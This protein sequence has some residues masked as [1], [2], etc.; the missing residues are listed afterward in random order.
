VDDLKG[1]RA[2]VSLR[3]DGDITGLPATTGTT[4]YRIVQEALTNASRHAPGA[5]V[6]VAVVVDGDRVDVSVDS[7]GRPGDG[8]GMGLRNMCERAEAVGGTCTAGP[9]GRGWLVTASLPNRAG[10]DGRAG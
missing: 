7:S 5:A 10:P 8:T 6:L 9:G 2:D 3:I 1:A 4:V